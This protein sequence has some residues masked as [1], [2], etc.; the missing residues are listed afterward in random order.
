MAASTSLSRYNGKNI[1]VL[2]DNK[3]ILEALSG[4]LKRYLKDCTVLTAST[5]VKGAEILRSMPIDLIL[6]DLDLRPD[7]GYLFIENTRSSYPGI[8]LCVMTGGCAPHVQ[9][10]LQRLG[11]S[12]YI[13]KP[14]PVE[15]LAAMISEELRRPEKEERT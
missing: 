9:E 13:E 6:T 3:F 2:D 15:H 12:R 4:M 7:D 5:S 8:P 10:R 14:F 11:I 1:L